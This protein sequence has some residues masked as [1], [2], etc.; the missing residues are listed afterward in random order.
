MPSRPARR[1]WFHSCIVKP[2]TFDPSARS[3]A[4]TVEEST[5]PDIATA[6]V[7]WFGILLRLWSDGRP[8]PSKYNLSWTGEDARPPTIFYC[9]CDGV[10]GR[11]RPPLHGLA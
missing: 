3:M 11:G 2:M 10:G 5:P 9:T 1:R 4:A 6:M 8:R 7:V